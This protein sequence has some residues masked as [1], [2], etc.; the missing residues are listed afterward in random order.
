MEDAGRFR[1]ARQRPG[2]VRGREDAA[3]AQG[4]RQPQGHRHL[5]LVGRRQ[6]DPRSARRRALPRRDRRQRPRSQAAPARATCSTRCSARPASIFRS[7]ATIGCGPVAVGSRG[8]ADHSEGG[9]AR[10]LGRGRVRRSGG[11]G[12]PA[13]AIGGRPTDARIA[14]ERFDEA[15]VGVV[16]R[17][18]IGADGHDDLRAALSCGRHAQCRCPAVRHRSGRRPQGEGRPRART[19]TSTWRASTGRP[20][21]RRSTSSARTATRPCST[22]SRSIRRPGKSRLLFSEKAAPR[23]WINLTDNYKFLEGRQPDL[24]V[25]ARRLRAPLPLRQRAMDAADQGPVGGEGPG[26]RRSGRAP[27]V[28]HRHQGRRARAAGLFDRLSRTRASR[29]G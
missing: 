21:A 10:P 20:T 18:A 4:H 13:P 14:V 12:P 5:R 28:L 6:V 29:S 16:T 25:G 2:H 23:H 22:C 19:A 24:V 26:R 1:E 3:R 17:A 27:A 8:Q 7:C 9:R 11:N 15:P